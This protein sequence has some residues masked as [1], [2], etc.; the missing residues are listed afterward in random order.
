MSKLI[1]G[2]II[3]FAGMVLK[4]GFTFAA[5][6]FISLGL[7]AVSYFLTGTKVLVRMLQNIVKGKIF[8]ENFLM[9]AAT[10]GAIAVGEYSGAAAVMVFYQI[11]EFLSDMAVAKSKKNIASLMDIRPDY[12]NIMINGV[13]HTVDPHTVQPGDTIVVK[14]GEKIPLDGVVMSG[15]SMLNMSALTG[16]SM[17]KRAG[18]SDIVLS[19]CVNQNGLLTIEVTRNFGESTASKIIDL[20]E[21]AAARKAKVETF[22]TK[23]AR[24]YTPVVMALALLIAVVPPLF[25]D[26]LWADWIYRSLVLLIIAC[27]CALVMSIPLG[28]FGGIGAASKKGILIKGGNY[29]EALASPDIL[30]FDKT[31]TLTKGV[32]KVTGIRTANGFGENQVLEA[33]ACVESF[34]NHP[35]ALSIQNAYGNEK[36]KEDLSQYCEIAGYGVSGTANGKTIL[37]GNGKLM[38]AN[39]I[40]YTE[41]RDI[42]TKV[43]VAIENLYAGCIIIADEIKPDS[44]SAISSLKA[45]G[46][47]KTVMLSG[48]TH[49]AAQ[50]VAAE[51]QLDDVYAGLLPQDKVEKLDVLMRQK[52]RGKALAFV[53]DGINDAPVLALADVGVAMGALG[54]DA[55]I[56]AADV[57]L[58][59]D[60]PSK[61][62][63]AVKVARFT[64]RIIWQNIIFALGVQFLFLFLGAMGVASIWEAI[65]ADVGVS[66]LAVLNTWRILKI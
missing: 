54:S 58:M 18:V 4:Y 41:S 21:N 15:E 5:S 42:G 11:G 20:V 40:A 19:G 23:F 32:F 29:L 38:S 50:A 24:Y 25:F 7:F 65:F 63:D 56:E 13:L 22:I 27:P 17:P 37:A 43:Y 53:G 49:E 9:S 28:F 39:G 64:K 6:E 26:G 45:L 34:S 44:R 48:D 51:V 46:V 12:A 55:A 61:L 57:V 16:E 62:I 1:I 59:T 66:L 8:D 52:Q 35:I 36:N 31:G 10:I 3:F 60:E 33:A 14:P 30:V 2:T 47:R